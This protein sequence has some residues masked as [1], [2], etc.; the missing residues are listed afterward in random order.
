VSDRRDLSRKGQPR[1]GGRAPSTPDNKKNPAFELA[2]QHGP[3]VIEGLW[4]I[5]LKSRSEP[6][7]IAA[8]K[9]LLDRAYGRPATVVAG[10]GTGEP[11]IVRHEVKWLD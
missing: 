1:T 11:I 9:E 2:R 3:K 4:E 7:R 6:M 8:A 10:D 5:F